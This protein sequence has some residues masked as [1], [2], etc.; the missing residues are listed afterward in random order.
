MDASSASL[1]LN[2]SF[3]SHSAVSR[4]IAFRIRVTSSSSSFPFSAGVGS[5][6][7]LSVLSLPEPCLDPRI[8][9]LHR[10]DDL[11]LVFLASILSWTLQE[12]RVVGRPIGV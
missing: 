11:G 4:A 2:S 6:L 12:R 7:A 5:S 3:S 9:R 1:D 8:G 10:L